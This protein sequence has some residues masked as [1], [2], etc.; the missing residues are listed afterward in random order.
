[1]KKF[2]LQDLAD[3]LPLTMARTD[4]PRLLGGIVSSKT[5]ANADSSGT[6]PQG[7]FKLGRKVAY[8]TSQLLSWLEQRM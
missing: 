2:A 7:R 4:V 1:M 5:L 3:R 8:E 6:G